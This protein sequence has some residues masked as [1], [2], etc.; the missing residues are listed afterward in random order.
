MAFI[1]LCLKAFFDVKSVEH[2]TKFFLL[3]FVD[4][5]LNHWLFHLRPT[6]Y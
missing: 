4:I 1:I 2:S 3:Q 5:H 6:H